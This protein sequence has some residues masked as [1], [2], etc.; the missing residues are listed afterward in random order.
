MKNKRKFCGWRIR[1][2][3]QCFDRISEK[4]EDFTKSQ[5][6]DAKIKIKALRMTWGAGNIYLYRVYKKYKV[7]NG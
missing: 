4:S 1:W 5:Y 6:K 3:Q 7:K 2:E